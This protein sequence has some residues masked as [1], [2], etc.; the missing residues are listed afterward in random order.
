M[1]TLKK[2]FIGALV[3]VLFSLNVNAGNDGDEQMEIVTATIITGKVIDITTGEVI[4][5][6]KIKLQETN[7]IVY[8]DFEGNFEF[9]GIIPGDYNIST[10]MISYEEKEK[11][12]EITLLEKNKI[13]IKLETLN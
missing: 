3:T 2:L 12:V 5:G 4:I 8:T 10:T 1:K 11:N 13:E 6:A 9:S 7:A